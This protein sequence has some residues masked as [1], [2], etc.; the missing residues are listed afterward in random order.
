MTLHRVIS[1]S[2]RTCAGAVVLGLVAACAGGPAQQPATWVPITDVRMVVG[3]WKGTLKKNDALL[4]A[5]EVHLIIRADHTYFFAA[6]TADEI[7]V[8]AGGLAIVDG[9]LI[10][11]TERRFVTFSLYEQGGKMVMIVDG[12]KRATQDRYHGEFSKNGDK[13]RLGGPLWEVTERNAKASLARTLQCPGESGD[14]CCLCPS[15]DSICAIL[16]AAS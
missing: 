1:S 15:S 8:G 16:A 9:Q 11:D 5:G 2:R 13:S 10:G 14:A 4:A 12:T 6:E 7:A 3:E